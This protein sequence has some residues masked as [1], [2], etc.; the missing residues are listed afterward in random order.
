MART[1]ERG[2]GMSDYLKPC[3]FCGSAPK[4]E[5]VKGVLWLRC[6]QCFVGIDPQWYDGDLGTVE[7][8]WNTRIGDKPLRLINEEGKS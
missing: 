3:P 4:Y 7:A 6:S 2:E 1:K 8:S 5:H